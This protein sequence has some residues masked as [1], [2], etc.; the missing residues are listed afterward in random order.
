MTAPLT[1][2]KFVQRTAVVAHTQREPWDE[3]V[4]SLGGQPFQSWAWG[5][6]KSHFGWRPY[7]L[8]TS[9]GTAAAQVLIRPYRGLAV[10]YVP[11]GPILSA[12]PKSNEALINSIVA[13]RARN[14]PR[15]C[16]SSRTCSRTTPT[17]AR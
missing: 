16:A 10:A 8:A 9:D 11:R 1:K 17:A 7:R 3:L 4:A 15:S 2:R 5:D 6:L 14:A 13:E 12:D